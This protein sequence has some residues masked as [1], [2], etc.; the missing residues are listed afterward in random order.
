MA[1]MK[2][3]TGDGPL[4]ATKEG[5]GIVMRVPLEG[6]GKLLDTALP[7]RLTVLAGSPRIGHQRVDR[8]GQRPLEKRRVA[9]VV[10]HQQTRLTVRDHLR[11]AADIG[12][13]H[14]RRAG[15]RLQVHNPQ[16]FVYRWA[17]ENRCC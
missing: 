16:R 4:E 11:Y 8:L 7:P 1:A 14:G 5:R 3:R 17:D 2:P 15:H 6:A 13:D 10:V 9:R 12:G